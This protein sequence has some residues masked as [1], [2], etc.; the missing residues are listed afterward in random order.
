M[1]TR[2]L[3]REESPVDIKCQFMEVVLVIFPGWESEVA[4]LQENTAHP[5]ES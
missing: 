3:E 4:Q 1:V 5:L 2:V